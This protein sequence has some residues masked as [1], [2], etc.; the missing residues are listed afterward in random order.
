MIEN[1][2]S[3]MDVA[4]KI[5]QS[6]AFQSIFSKT[7]VHIMQN[8]ERNTG[9]EGSRANLTVTKN[10]VSAIDRKGRKDLQ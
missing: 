5:E 7:Q 3:A 9:T 1:E 10:Q 8:T 2:V 4:G 6:K